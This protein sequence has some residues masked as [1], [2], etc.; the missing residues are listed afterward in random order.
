[1]IDLPQKIRRARLYKDLTQK[2]LA[3]R[4]GV[5]MQ[6]IHRIEH[7]KHTPSLALLERL[8]KELDFMIM[9]DRLDKLHEI[10]NELQSR[11]STTE[12]Q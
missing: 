1:M 9:D 2:E 6:T 10:L 11:L 3:Q 5:S 4:V 12:K 8:S 7:G